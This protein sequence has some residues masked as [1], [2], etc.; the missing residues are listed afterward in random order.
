MAAAL[1]GLGAQSGRTELKAEFFVLKEGRIT[2]LG[3]QLLRLR[4][5][6]ASRELTGVPTDRLLELLLKYQAA[7]KDE[8]VE[9]RPLSDFEQARLRTLSS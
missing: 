7:L 2:L 8:F 1:H 9:V 3:E 6:L 4:G 5:E